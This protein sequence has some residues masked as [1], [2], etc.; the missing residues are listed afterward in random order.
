MDAADLEQHQLERLNQ[1]LDADPA[2]Q[3]LLR[4]DAGRICGCR[5]RSLDDLAQLPFTFK[6]DLVGAWLRRHATARWPGI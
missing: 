4:R 1:L 2:G 5:S 3:F 6:E